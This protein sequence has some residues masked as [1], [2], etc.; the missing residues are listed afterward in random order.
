M[1]AEDVVIQ[2]GNSIVKFVSGIITKIKPVDIYNENIKGLVYKLLPLDYAW[3]LTIHKCQ[4]MTLDLCIM[5][6]GSNIFADGQTYVALSRNKNL[7]G[8][9]LLSFDPHKI[10][11]NK[12]V[13]EFYDKH[14]EQV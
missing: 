9:Y 6:I 4:G 11:S 13:V 14:T 2:I 1:V 8:L 3:A 5:D 10:T 7:E 12:K